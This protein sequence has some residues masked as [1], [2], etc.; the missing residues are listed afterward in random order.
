M[1]T[2]KNIYS[3]L[4]QHDTIRDVLTECLKDKKYRKEMLERLEGDITYVQSCMDTFT[5]NKKETHQVIIRDRK[6]ERTITISPYFPN[7][8]FDYLVVAPLKP[9]IKKSMYRWNVGNV[10]GRGKDMGIQFLYSHI[11]GYKYAIKLDVKKFYD[12]IDKKILFK[13]V[14]R[15]VSDSDFLRM[16][17]EVIGATG[18]GLD[19]GLNSSQWLANYYLQGLD[20]F[21]KQELKAEVYVRYVDD[22]IILGNNKRK[23]H[24]FIRAINQYLKEKLNLKLKENYALLNLEKGESVEFVGYKIS[25]KGIQLIK[26]L[27]HKFIR[28]YKRMKDMSKRRAKTLVALWGWF[29]ATTGSYAY[30]ISHLRDTIMFS[31]VK[32]LLRRTTT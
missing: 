3:N 25:H 29:K 27:F 17:E 22:M 10:E 4:Y 19:L 28:L 32:R 15:K 20:Y 1:K 9:M 7:K 21:I 23:L 24:Y 12:N 5:F 6:K 2:L 18:K 13:L 30:Y 31:E 16:Y 8:I 14:K 26:P 11:K